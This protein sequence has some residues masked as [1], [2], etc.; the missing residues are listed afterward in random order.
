MAL[1]YTISEAARYLGVSCST[2]RRWDRGG[3]FP[4]QR[5][6]GNHRRY[7]KQMLDKFLGIQEENDSPESRI[8]EGLKIPY[9]Y[10]RVSTQHQVADGNLTRQVERIENYILRHH[11]SNANYKIIKECGSGM[12]LQ[13]TGLKQLFHAVKKRKISILYLEYPDRLSRFGFTFLEHW[14]KDYNVEI[15]IIEKKV[16]ITLEMEFIDDVMTILT[17]FSGKLYKNRSLERSKQERMLKKERKAIQAQ[18]DE[19]TNITIQKII[20]S[21]MVV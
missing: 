21:I 16:D 19:S 5:T 2:L 9:G 10:A 7:S 13:R 4:S 18:I 6:I 17:S 20:Q 8:E 14:F 3:K 15:R 12:N 1:D 11:G